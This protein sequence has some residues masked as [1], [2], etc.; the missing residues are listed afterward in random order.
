MLAASLLEGSRIEQTE[1]FASAI[2]NHFSKLMDEEAQ[3][4]KKQREKDGGVVGTGRSRLC[5]NYRKS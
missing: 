1:L 4:R 5:M 3:R 2:G